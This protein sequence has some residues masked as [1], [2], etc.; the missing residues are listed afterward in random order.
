MLLNHSNVI[1]KNS[2]VNTPKPTKS[3]HFDVLL[4]RIPHGWLG[5]DQIDE[6][7][8]RESLQLAHEH[9]GVK[10]TIITN[11]PLNNNIGDIDGVIAQKNKNDMIRKF[12][13]SY[14]FEMAQSENQQTMMFPSTTTNTTIQHLLLM[15]FGRFVNEFTIINAEQIG[16]NTTGMDID[17]LFSQRLGDKER[18]GCN[19]KIGSP[20]ALVCAENVPDGSCACKKNQVSC[21]GMHWCMETIGGKVVAALA[22]LMQ[23]PLKNGSPEEIVQVQ[24]CEE[25]CNS[26]FMSMKPYPLIDRE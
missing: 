20:I 9:F 25:E 23:C 11:L 26:R 24:E 16:M 17:E 12:I 5:L 6:Q 7:R 2:L 21:D 19:N 18:N 15:D 13:D 3:Q 10:T 8:I 14:R 4:Y 22:C 1:Q